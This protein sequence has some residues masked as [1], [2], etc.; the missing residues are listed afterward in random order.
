MSRKLTKTSE[1]VLDYFYR[2]PDR[3]VHI[4]GLADE[5]GIAYSSVRNALES[6]ESEGLVTKREESKMTFY[7]ANRND[8]EFKRR[9]RLRNLRQLYETGMVE[10]LEHQLRPDALVLFGSYLEGNDRSD[11]DIDIAVV[12]GRT[13][14]VDLSEFE[15]SLGRTLQ[16]VAI[17]D[18]RDEKQDFR[19]TLANGFVLSG[20]LTVI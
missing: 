4:R 8:G 19:N 10:T 17:D 9:K 15:E 6:L 18:A 14:D 7:S 5:T 11:S 16:L 1:S 2:Y 13:A 20:H 12:N 3:E